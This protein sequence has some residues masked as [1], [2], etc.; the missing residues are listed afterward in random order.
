MPQVLG[1]IVGMIGAMLLTKLLLPV[2]R[3]LKIVDVPFT[4]GRKIHARPMVLVGGVAIAVSFSLVIWA[5]TFIA[6][7][8][9]PQL[10]AMQWQAL[11]F[12]SLVLFFVG[13]IDD[14][15]GLP[16]AVQLVGP[17]VATA[18]V[19]LAGIQI[20]SVTRPLG[21]I[22]LF[23]AGSGVT[24][25]LT[26]VWLLAMMYGT[27]LLD[28]LD[29][30]TTGLS[31]IGA[32]MIF[33]L[34]QTAQFFE[35]RLGFAS[36]VFAGC[37]AGF[38]FFNFYPARAFLGEGGSLFLGFV[39]AVLSILSGSK[40]ATALLVMGLA[41]F[42]VIR[43]ILVRM[44][45]GKTPFAADQ[46]HLHHLLLRSGVSH[47]KA[48]LLYYVCGIACGLLALFLPTVGKILLLIAL[49]AGEWMLAAY[50]EKRLT[51]K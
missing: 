14:R 22:I 41:V 8:Y 24:I 7:T 28:G 50:L 2:F 18:I 49:L 11:I 42:D 46:R 37:C 29:G 45:H 35:P 38:L 12:A 15:F 39:L 47:R 40:I 1:G 48:V 19:V 9:V 3:Y 44:S 10:P 30:L 27:K 5:A 20:H 23:S 17:L 4:S 6:P 16:P 43:L 32:V 31:G 21:G 34:T 26:S 51:K 25:F 36:L 13:I 33:A